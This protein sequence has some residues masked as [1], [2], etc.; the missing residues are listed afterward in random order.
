MHVY[1]DACLLSRVDEMQNG[2]HH[3]VQWDR[4]LDLMIGHPPQQRLNGPAVID[5]AP[6]VFGC[7]AVGV[8]CSGR[9]P[10]RKNLEWGAQQN[11][12]VE[13]CVELRLVLL[14]AR[15][16]QDVGVFG[17]Q[18]CLDGVF[19]PPLTAVRQRLGPPFVGVDRFEP[20]SGQLAD[21]ARLPGPRHPG[22]ENSPHAQSVR[23]DPGAA[24]R[25]LA[26]PGGTKPSGA[27][28]AHLGTVGRWAP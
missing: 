28:R 25:P 19:P 24:G 7:L 18:Q 20:A 1:P 11:D 26:G 12:A 10:S 13:L 5:N 21:N 2:P 6:E 27:M 9:Q 15:D 3:L 8:A 14:A 22:Q 16:E 23:A 4:C 17:G